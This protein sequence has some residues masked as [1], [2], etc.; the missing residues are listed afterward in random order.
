MVLSSPSDPLIGRPVLHLLTSI[1]H[2]E[3]GGRAGYGPCSLSG[4][5]SCPVPLSRVLADP[6]SVIIRAQQRVTTL[7]PTSTCRRGL[8]LRQSRQRVCP[9]VPA[10]SEA[11]TAS[12]APGE[13]ERRAAGF[14]GWRRGFCRLSDVGVVGQRERI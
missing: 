3:T 9:R 8:F 14:G 2:T 4:A 1:R 7:R 5:P 13:A 6:S 10:S 12:Q 11:G